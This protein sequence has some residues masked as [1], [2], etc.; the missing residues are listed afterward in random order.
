MDARRRLDEE[1][2]LILEQCNN[3]AAGEILWLPAKYMPRA[4]G[5]SFPGPSVR[6]LAG[7]ASEDAGGVFSSNSAPEEEED[8]P[9]LV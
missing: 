1:M 5:K 6:F 8:M 7:A 3:L 9:D 2:R 4:C